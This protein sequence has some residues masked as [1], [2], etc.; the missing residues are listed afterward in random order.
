[1]SV[2]LLTVL[3]LNVAANLG[4]SL[5]QLRKSETWRPPLLLDCGSVPCVDDC[6][7]GDDGAT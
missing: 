1:M 6:G 4:D 2:S 3:N 5:R 7:H